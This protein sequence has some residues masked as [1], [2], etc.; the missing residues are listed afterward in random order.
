MSGEKVRDEPFD[1]D[2]KRMI[3]DDLHN[4]A[5]DKMPENEAA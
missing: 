2:D 4:D 1:R 3:Y 5:A